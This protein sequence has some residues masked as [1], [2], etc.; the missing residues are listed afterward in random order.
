MTP[1][2]RRPREADHE[3]VSRCSRWKSWR[4]REPLVDLWN[5]SDT[6]VAEYRQWAGTKGH[7]DGLVDRMVRDFKEKA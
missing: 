5:V 2:S 3:Y 6:E 4:D 1:P 7:H